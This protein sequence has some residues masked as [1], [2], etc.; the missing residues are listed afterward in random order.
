MIEQRDKTSTPTP[1]ELATPGQHWA[2]RAGCVHLFLARVNPQGETLARHPLCQID[3]DEVLFS[4][5]GAVP[6]GWAVVAQGMTETRL[7]RVAQKD[8]SH[9]HAAV[10][11]AKLRATVGLEE[12]AEEF[13]WEGMPAAQREIFAAAAELQQQRESAERARIAKRRVENQRHIN[14]SFRRLSSTL[15]SERKRFDFNPDVDD[16]LFAAC[17]A[18]G[19]EAGISF[20]PPVEML[21]QLPMRDPLAAIARA[22][23]VRTRKV[24]LSERIWSAAEQ[25]FLARRE[26]DGAPLAFLPNGRRGYNVFDPATRTTVK[27]TE[28]M[29]RSLEPFGTVFYRPFPARKLGVRDVVT[30]G[31]KGSARDMWVLVL[32]G[33]LA[34]L[35]GTVAPLVTSNIFDHMIPTA[36]RGKLLL[37]CIFLI[38]A[39][40]AAILFQLVQ[41]FAVLRIE[42]R[43]ESSLQAALWDRILNLPV[44][45]FRHYSA[46]DLATRGMAI[47]E[48]RRVLSS[49]ALS[50]IFAAVFSVFSYALLF[51]FS[52]QLAL[53]ATALTALALGITAVC[54]H[55]YVRTQREIFNIEGKIAGTL[56]E[57]VQ[58]IAKF[59]IAGAEDRAFVNWAAA[60]AK[61]KIAASRTARLNLVLRVFSAIFPLFGAICIFFVMERQSTMALSTGNFL[62]FVLAYGQFTGAVMVCATNFLPMLNVVPLYERARPILEAVPETSGLKAAS[63]ELMG[64]VEMSQVAFRYTPGGP[65]ILNGISC[66]IQPGEFVAFVGTSGAGKSTLLR[67][68]LGFEKP[69]T[70]TIYFDGQELQNLDI[71]SVRQKM[72]VVLQ[73]ATLFSGD[74]YSNIIGSSPYS[75]DEAWEAAKLAGCDAEIRALPMGMHTALGEGGRGLSGGQRQRIMIARALVG[76]PRILIFDEATSAL[77]N[78]TQALVSRSLE[79]LDVTRIVI[80]HRLSTI[81]HADRIFVMDG[82]RI[83]QTGTYDELMQQPGL[84]AALVAR[85]VI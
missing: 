53:V 71:Q 19:R 79:Q 15:V 21:R 16:A 28:A 39:A 7:E 72:G 81:V 22:S 24:A 23:S 57:A 42:G 68:L 11:L 49:A 25:P 69:E 3:A 62:A 2:V 12:S 40:I 20:T 52:V 56:L 9:E 65:L 60:F 67:L 70:G 59:R 31:L 14:D 43:M 48:M 64:Q 54:G 36:E 30:F 63:R 26:A 80:A 45:F 41:S 51:Y 66:E 77:D 85:Q 82:G 38:T 74:I 5:H 1:A 29:V 34:G 4:V 50:S 83:V 76:K 35:L 46:G 33:S 73:N 44:P 47:S 6:A 18:L 32:T 27:V 8:V 78:H 75:M 55:L 37:S 84:F 58:G 13:A 61:Q 10:W 17:E